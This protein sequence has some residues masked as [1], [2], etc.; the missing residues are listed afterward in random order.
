MARRR[1]SR[2]TESLVDMRSRMPYK[3]RLAQARRSRSHGGYDSGPRQFDRA[4][5]DWI[6]SAPD[7]PAH[8]KAA[9]KKRQAADRSKAKSGGKGG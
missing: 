1:A 9:L 5:R 4:T 3:L 8:R 2:V 7:A 6:D